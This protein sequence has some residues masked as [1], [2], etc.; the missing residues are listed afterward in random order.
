[1]LCWGVG[2]RLGEVMKS[3][4]LYANH[5]RRGCGVLLHSVIVEVFLEFIKPITSVLM[6]ANYIKCR[7][8]VY[9]TL[10]T[11]RELDYFKL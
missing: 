6:S 9:F 3:T 2:R 1:M 4:V 7:M 8:G 11:Q 5:T 10:P